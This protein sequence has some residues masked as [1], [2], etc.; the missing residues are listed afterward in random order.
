L[1]LV[2]LDKIDEKEARKF[3][4]KTIGKHGL[5]EKLNVDKSCA[6]EAALLTINISL[7]LLGI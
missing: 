3:F 2:V 4:K 5:P 7:F 1:E 6:N